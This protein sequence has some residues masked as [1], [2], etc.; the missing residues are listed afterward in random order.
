MF[1]DFVLFITHKFLFLFKTV[2]SKNFAR[3]SI[4]TVSW[5]V[6]NVF[7]LLFF[8][9]YMLLI[10][11]HIINYNRLFIILAISFCFLSTNVLLSLRYNKENY[12]L[13][14]S[15]LE[16]RYTYSRLK[17]CILFCVFFFVPLLSLGIGTVF[18]R[19]ILYQG[20]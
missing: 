20:I 10:S 9:V 7:L 15:K 13:A 2:D 8:I 19:N 12:N 5:I 3:R 4:N 18:L 14:I 17:I 1:L 16:G 11:R 6:C